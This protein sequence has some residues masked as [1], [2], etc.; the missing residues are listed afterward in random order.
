MQQNVR[1]LDS[2]TGGG[3]P[4]RHAVVIGG[5]LA[6]LLAAHVL[7]EHA[8]RVTIVERDRFPEEPV[9]RPGVPQDRHTHVLLDSGQQALE[10]LLP[11]ITGELREQGS[12]QVGMPSDVVQWQ[13]GK[14]Y[15]RTAATT[16]IFTGSR[17]LTDW[18][19][20]RRVL[21][22]PRIGTV[23]GA[24]VTGLV[25]NTT[26]VRG[27]RLRERG[28][29]AAGQE[30]RIL[31]ADL[32]VDASGRSSRAPDWLTALGA[33]RPHEE[34]LDTGLAYATRVFRSPR[35]AVEPSFRGIYVVP[36][37]TQPVGGILLPLEDDRWSVILSGLRGAEPPTD[38]AGFLEFA[39]R[40]PHPVLY[41]WLLKAEPVSPV[42]GFRKTANLRRRY[43]RPGRR[44]AGFL[45]TGEAL[46]AFNPVYGQGMSVA[47]LSAV[48]LREALSDPRRV[49]TTHRVQRALFAAARPAWDISAGAD[50]NVPGATGNAVAPRLVDRP[51]DWY[52]HRVEQR[53][54][55]NPAVGAA[56]RRVLSLNAPAT[57]LFAPSVARAVLFGPTPW[58]PPEPP[59]TPEADATAR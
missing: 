47:A 59:L 12:P 7:A 30:S 8:D 38:E 15:R 6:G 35:G 37:P 41:E 20:R 58:T 31:E 55:G 4:R 16:R 18:V 9:S 14:W 44:P 22:G 51:V 34:L 56:F 5:G 2:R 26:R 10:T 23:E 49:P 46:C 53:A 39:S 24:E 57:S 43:D 32:V 28:A 17:P 13:G 11:G 25:G 54:T 42:H 1:T 29:A 50:K 45:A 27:V 40:L 21:A 33:E 3:S 36:N 19:V 48:A 52:L